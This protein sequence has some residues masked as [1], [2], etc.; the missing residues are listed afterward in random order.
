MHAETLLFSWSLHRYMGLPASRENMKHI[1]EHIN[2]TVNTTNTDSNVENSFLQEFLGLSHFRNTSWFPLAKSV[3]L[4]HQISQDIFVS[5]QVFVQ[6]PSRTALHYTRFKSQGVSLWP[7]RLCSAFVLIQTSCMTLDKSPGACV[8]LWLPFLKPLNYLNQK[9][10][11][12]FHWIGDGWIIHFFG[13]VFFFIE[14]T[15]CLILFLLRN[16][17]IYTPRRLIHLKF[18]FHNFLRFSNAWTSHL[19]VF[20]PY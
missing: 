3:S 6:I 19:G 15:K 10:D 2:K 4:H 9:T 14:E 17:M 18:G 12:P 13:L 5:H 7:G 8:S 1:N 20:N 11:I 16:G